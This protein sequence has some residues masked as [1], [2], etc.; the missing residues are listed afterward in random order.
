MVKKTCFVVSRSFKVIVFSTNW[1]DIC[2]FLLELI[3]DPGLIAQGF[4]VTATYWSKSHLWDLPRY[5]LMP[6]LGVIPCENTSMGLEWP[7][8]RVNGLPKVKTRSSY[9]HSFW[10]NN[11]VWRTDGW[12]DRIAVAET[13]LSMVLAV[14][15]MTT[16]SAL[17][18]QSVC[19]AVVTCEIKLVWDDSEIITVVTCEMT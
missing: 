8:T 16:V 19:N 15:T 7:K 12:R 14:K 2:D 11:G 1:K 9:I 4:R 13:A 5:H 10:H 18:T 3:S 17:N 6:S